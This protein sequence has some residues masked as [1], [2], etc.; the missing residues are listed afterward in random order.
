MSELTLEEKI[1][2]LVKEHAKELKTQEQISSINNVMMKS[3]LEAALGAEMDEHLGY[4]KHS[5]EGHGSGNSRNGSTQKTLKGDFGEIEI[6]TPRDREGTFEPQL[7]RKRQTRLTGFDEQILAL[8]AR[9]M[10][11]RDIADSFQ[12]MYGAEVSH[13]LISKVTSAVVEE[14]KTWQSRPLNNLYPIVYFDC[15]VI[16]VHQDKRVINKS[17]YI[18]LGVDIDGHKEVLGLW[19]S[20]NEGA[21][22]WLSVLTELKNRGLDDILITCVDGLT[23]FPDAINTVYPK[24]YVQLCIVH[25]IR[26]SLKYVS[27]KHRKAVAQDLKSIYTAPT[28][29]AALDELTRFAEKW[30]DKYGSIS[31]MWH[32]H[33]DNIIPFLQYPPEIRKVIY[34]TNSIESLNSVI[35]KSIK[36]RKIFP[37]DTSALKVIYLAI[38]RASK[39]WTMPIRDWAT[40]LNRFNLEF[41][42]RLK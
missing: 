20:E 5:P 32:A 23:G 42:D 14:V 36:L 39:K 19:I 31:K 34:T 30:D 17:V 26:N 25:L 29:D 41:G 8:Y 37:N 13:S 1:R 12:E 6:E 7:I 3:V 18:A 2:R 28:S 4:E 33:W 24:A 22:F 11:T 9:G 21:K 35:R 40:A 10:T 16:K 15:I 38:E 27:Y